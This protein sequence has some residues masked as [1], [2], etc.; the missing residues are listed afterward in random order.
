M[1][2]VDSEGLRL[3]LSSLLPGLIIDSTVKASG[4][5]VVFFCHF[6]QSDILPEFSKWRNTISKWGDVVLKVTEELQPKEIAYLQNEITILNKLKSPYYPMLYYNEVFTHNPDTD[7]RLKNRIFVTVEEKIESIPLSECAAKFRS[8]L[9]ICEL[10]M[11]LVVGLSL[12][13]DHKPP[14]IHRD[15]KPENLLIRP[16]GSVVIIDLGIVREEGSIGLTAMEAPW[17]PCTPKYASPEQANN[18]RDNINYKSDFYLLGVLAYELATGENPHITSDDHS[19]G[20]VLD[21]VRFHQPLP[22]KESHALNGSFSDL[23]EKLLKKAPYQR[24]RSI[25]K[26]RENIVQTMEVLSGN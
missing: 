26:L 18:D 15:I 25:K 20:T 24:P 19:I 16:D 17:G 9:R 22:L 7:D 14:L 1:G 23:I 4:Q 5:R 2:T 11:N 10:L 12:L 3:L 8:P 13:W 6:E 21:N